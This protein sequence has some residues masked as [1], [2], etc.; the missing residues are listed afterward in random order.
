[1]RSVALIMVPPLSP[2][3]SESGCSRAGPAWYTPSPKTMRML[4]G[5]GVPSKIL[6]FA[7]RGVGSLLGGHVEARQAADSADDEAGSSQRQ[8]PL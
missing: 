5:I 8:V 3:M 4:V 2:S 6:H 1:M 7:G